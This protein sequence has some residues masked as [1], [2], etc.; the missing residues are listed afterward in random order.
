MKTPTQYCIV[1]EGRITATSQQ[2][3]EKPWWMEGEQEGRGLAGKPPK[4]SNFTFLLSILFSQIS[5]RCRFALIP[6]RPSTPSTLLLTHRKELVMLQWGATV[7]PIS[8][9]AAAQCQLSPHP[10]LEPREMPW[11]WSA[12]STQQTC[13]TP[14]PL[15]GLASY[16]VD[17]QMLCTSFC[18]VLSCLQL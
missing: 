18:R 7:L 3:E 17:Q 13:P 16:A 9:T 12:Q 5:I 15:P 10:R 14:N 6:K 8:S 4:C 11:G 2:K 1:T